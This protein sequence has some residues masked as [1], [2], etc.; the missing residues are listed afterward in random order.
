MSGGKVLRNRGSSQPIDLTD[1]DTPIS[2][3]EFQWQSFRDEV[4]PLGAPEVQLQ[5][6]QRAFYAG[7]QGVLNTVNEAFA[8]GLPAD[9]VGK[10]LPAI[11]VE[12]HRYAA[13]VVAKA[14]ATRNRGNKPH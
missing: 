5:E 9:E 10:V 7:A 4:I 14:E 8:E 11:G 1:P 13:A 3:L 2:L 12:V 6:M